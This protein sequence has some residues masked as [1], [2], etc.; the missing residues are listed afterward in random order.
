MYQYKKN[1]FVK[2]VQYHYRFFKIS[3]INKYINME[4]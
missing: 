1:L 4:Y 3:K 2:K